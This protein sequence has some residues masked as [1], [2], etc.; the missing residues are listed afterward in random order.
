MTDINQDFI[1][2]LFLKSN[3][4]DLRN[5]SLLYMNSTSNA[6]PYEVGNM[7]ATKEGNALFLQDQKERPK[8]TQSYLPFSGSILLSSERP[9]FP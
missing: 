7:N 6:R 9:L 4:M 2:E 8:I 5:R 3:G 1:A